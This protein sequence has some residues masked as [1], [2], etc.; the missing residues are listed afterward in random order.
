MNA[1]TNC[2]SRH[3]G[4]PEDVK[5]QKA[6][7]P[8]FLDELFHQRQAQLKSTPTA[9]IRAESSRPLFQPE[10]AEIGAK[11]N[12]QRMADYQQKLANLEAA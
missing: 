5:G 3:G 1:K 8:D 2:M 6:V 10:F 11:T 4:Q 9:G 12:V 7:A